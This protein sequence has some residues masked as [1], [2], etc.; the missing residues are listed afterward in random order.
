VAA[1]HVPIGLTG[2]QRLALPSREDM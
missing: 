1:T 2:A